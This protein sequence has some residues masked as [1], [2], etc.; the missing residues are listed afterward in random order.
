[1]SLPANVTPSPIF[2]AYWQFITE[3]QNIFWRRQQGESGPWTMDPILQKHKFTNTYRI[4]DRVSQFMLKNVIYDGVQ[5]TP[6]DTIFR[7]LLFKLFNK[8]STWGVFKHD[9]REEPSIQNFTVA[10]YDEILTAAQDRGET[11]SGNAYMMTAHGSF[12]D[13]RHRMYL[14]LL[15]QWMEEDLPGRVM[16]GSMQDCFNIIMK[17][18]T[19]KDFLSNQ[20]TLD[21]GYTDLVNWDENDF[22]AA[23]PGTQRGINK[24]FTGVKK[25]QYADIVRYVQETQEEHFQRL[26]LD[27]KYIGNRKLHLNDLSNCFCEFDKYCREAYPE[28]TV[29]M[30]AG[31]PVRSR[32]KQKFR[33]NSDSIPYIFPPKWN[34]TL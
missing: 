28:I 20:Y 5:R 34:I 9:L 8:N 15:N 14:R 33:E 17:Y 21:I 1:M 22:I 30:K 16:K 26:G 27:F 4:L 10:A 13:R 25:G 3:R 32:I 23:G 7:I 24:A 29:D 6:E 31:A 11:I 19:M 2:D 18:R 12:G